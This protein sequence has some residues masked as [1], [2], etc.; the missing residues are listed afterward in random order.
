MSSLT[1][2]DDSVHHV[3]GTCS[4]YSGKG[5][6]KGALP[7]WHTHTYAWGE[8][9]D[10]E[11]LLMQCLKTKAFFPS[12]HEPRNQIPTPVLASRLTVA[13]RPSLSDKTRPTILSLA[14]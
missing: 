12:Y 14:F 3:R 10:W 13:N 9:Q 5:K 6:V 4:Q 7:H 2:P 11:R 8:G 1:R